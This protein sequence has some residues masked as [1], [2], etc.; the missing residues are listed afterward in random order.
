[1]VDPIRDIQIVLLTNMRHSPV[2]EPPNGFATQSF[3]L[4][5]YA[6]LI[7]RVYQ[8]LA[9]DGRITDVDVP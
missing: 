9:E 5:H 6:G 7:C 3:P 2:T 1:M 4:A 8:A